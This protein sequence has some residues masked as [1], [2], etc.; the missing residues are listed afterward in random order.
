[1][2]QSGQSGTESLEQF[3]FDEAE[4][5]K[6]MQDLTGHADTTPTA[7]MLIDNVPF[8]ALLDFIEAQRVEEVE[9][10]SKTMAK[11]HAQM[12]EK[13]TRDRKA[14][15]QNHIDRTSRAFVEIPSK[16]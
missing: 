2:T 13:A 9:K 16:R 3:S 5:K 4:K 10:L 7:L 6:S 14:A 12:T 15:I 1:V 8:N 11:I